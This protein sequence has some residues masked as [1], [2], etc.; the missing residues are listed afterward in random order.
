M[1]SLAQNFFSNKDLIPA[2]H[3]ILRRRKCIYCKS[4]GN[5][6]QPNYRQP[7]RSSSKLL[8]IASSKRENCMFLFKADKNSTLICILYE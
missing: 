5:N 1:R 8:L 6:L 2:H 3:P 7:P 4:S